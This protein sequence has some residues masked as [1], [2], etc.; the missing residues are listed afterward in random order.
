MNADE[1]WIEPKP[2][3]NNREK[4]FKAIESPKTLS[5]RMRWKEL[6]FCRYMGLAK[7]LNL[8]ETF[9][10]HIASAYNWQEL[11]KQYWQKR[12][13]EHSEDLKKRQI[14]VEEKHFK[15][16][17]AKSQVLQIML[18]D[19]IQDNKKGIVTD[20]NDIIPLFKQLTELAKDER[21]NVHLPNNYQDIKADVQADA[22]ID[23][24]KYFDEDKLKETTQDYV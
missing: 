17:N 19:V 16:N 22:S 12:S 21:I 20:I 7:D 18:N 2:K 10:R 23:L 13:I 1:W 15:I 3:T 5:Y 9:I 4:D 24:S 8:S 14:E 11:R 6:G